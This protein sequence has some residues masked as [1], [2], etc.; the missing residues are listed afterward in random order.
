MVEH[1]R[2]PKTSLPYGRGPVTS[3]APAHHRAR[4]QAV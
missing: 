2:P 1:L 3:S 4:K